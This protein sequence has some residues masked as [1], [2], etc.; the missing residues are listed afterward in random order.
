MR[1]LRIPFDLRSKLCVGA[2][3]RAGAGAWWPRAT[4][5]AAWEQPGARPARPVLH[6]V[7]RSSNPSANPCSAC[8]QV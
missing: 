8:K 7:P 3:A 5:A 2:G 4:A 1:T 6:G